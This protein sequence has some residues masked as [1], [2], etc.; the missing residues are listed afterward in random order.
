MNEPNG[1]HENLNENPNENPNENHDDNIAAPA[2]P[3]AEGAIGPEY[4][5]WAREPLFDIE[6]L[7]DFKV[8]GC[9][10][11]HMVLQ[12]RVPCAVFGFSRHAGLKVKG[13]WYGR[14]KETAE[15]EVGYNGCFR[16]EFS[17][18]EAEREPSVMIISSSYGSYIFSDILVGDIWMIGGQSNAEYH[19]E[20]CINYTPEL[21]GEMS[22][23]DNFRLFH[24][25]QAAAFEFR[26]NC[27]KPSRDIIVPT[28][29]WKRPGR[30]ASLGFSAMGY[31]FAKELTR[32]TDVPLGLVMICA[33]GAC[34]REL[35]PYDLSVERGYTV[36]ANMPVGGYYNTLIS[37]FASF[38]FRGQLFFQG[39]SEGIWKEMAWSYDSDLAAFVE[40]ERTTFGVDFPFY[41]VQLSSYRDE[42]RQYFP[43]L[44]I[45]RARQ[46]DA[47]SEIR[48]SYIAV[49]MDL[50]SLP[51][52]S[53]F[54][55]S[56]HKAELGRRLA[57][58]VYAHE[59]GGDRKM[60]DPA[61][62]ESPAPVLLTETEGGY[63]IIFK[64]IG[65]GLK[66]RLGD[67]PAGFGFVPE[68]EEEQH[69]V[70]AEI[71]APDTVFVSI[72]EAAK[73]LKIS[74]VSYAFTHPGYPENANIV[75]SF[76]L[77][78]PAFILKADQ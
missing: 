34:I 69:S 59:Y 38:P 28:W 22:E 61:E 12:R 30:S 11:S 4:S 43:F 57:M 78:L 20:S 54:A 1:K 13:V 37:P 63:E 51:S 17:P 29:S 32:Y 26:E 71:V 65:E 39:E 47:V 45:V 7:P 67:E 36:G 41:N 56:P 77:P 14:Y 58:Q 31:Y 2:L 18:R 16:L 70:K 44:H 55:H 23:E 74:Y 33:G 25:S 48:R 53:D 10:S 6:S 76:G 21:L 72:G 73:D 8:S 9:F 24:Q 68:G 50:G 64:N 60:P 62:Y 27:A 49:A 66:T 40:D 52:D 3:D 42:G 35:M 15:T 75:N 46:F 5:E 19:L